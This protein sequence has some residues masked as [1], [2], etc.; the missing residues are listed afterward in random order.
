MSAVAL[1]SDL[2]SCFTAVLTRTDTGIGFFQLRPA[3]ESSYVLLME[4]QKLYTLPRTKNDLQEPFKGLVKLLRIRVCM[5][6]FAAWDNKA[7]F[8]L[9]T[10]NN[11][12]FHVCEQ[13]A[14]KSTIEMYQ[15][16]RRS[17]HLSEN[18]ASQDEEAE[19]EDLSWM[20]EDP[21]GLFDPN[22]VVDSSPLGPDDL[23]PGVDDHGSQDE[24]DYDH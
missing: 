4:P 11:C 8:G 1:T 10:S 20:I 9:Y 6:A 19:E 24:S 13:T 5:L 3:T 21:V 18:V 7:V 2:Y 15:E 14:L 22:I 23:V 17:P 12:S 16:L